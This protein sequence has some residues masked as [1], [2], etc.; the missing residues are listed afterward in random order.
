MR[1][2]KP[3]RQLA[4]LCLADKSELFSRLENEHGFTIRNADTDQ[5][6]A[7]R[8]GAI[9][10]LGVAHAD[11]VLESS[12]FAHSAGGETVYSPELD[13]RLGI[14]TLLHGLPAIGCAGYSIL[15]TDN[16]EIG[17]STA[18]DFVPP[19]DYNW[20]FQFDRRGTGAVAYEFSDNGVFDGLLSSAFGTLHQGS[21]SDICKLAHLGVKAMNVGTAYYGEHTEGCYADMSQLADQM[22]RFKRF[23]TA[24]Q[25]WRLP[26]EQKRRFTH[27]WPMPAPREVTR[28]F[29]DICYDEVDMSFTCPLPDGTYICDDCED[30]INI[31]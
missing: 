11:T 2:P 30:S 6:Y 9:P 10:V 16:E 21:F 24:F 15:I 23:F 27:A 20:L 28:G 29:C 12:Y 5:Q 31:A 22:L 17:Q 19:R 25:G 14:W 3:T 4:T 13:D 26:H 7:Y 18:G 1:T 8:A